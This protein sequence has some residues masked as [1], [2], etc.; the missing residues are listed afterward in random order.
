MPTSSPSQQAGHNLA[1]TADHKVYA[2]GAGFDYFFA[3]DDNAFTNALGTGD[4]VRSTP[5]L[6]PNL[7]D[8]KAIA[9]NLAFSLALSTDGRVYTWGLD[10]FG[11]HR[12]GAGNVLPT[13]P[14]DAGLG[15]ITAIAAGG[16]FGVALDEDGGVWQWGD[17][18]GTVFAFPYLNPYQPPRC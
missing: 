18:T 15:G 1:L 7:P 10:T 12:D 9:A 14:Y 11:T 3:W 17:R 6:V 5:T 8:I 4:M 13:G 16:G 2:W